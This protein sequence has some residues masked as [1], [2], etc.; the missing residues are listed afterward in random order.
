M[1]ENRREVVVHIGGNGK[2]GGGVPDDGELHMTLPEHGCTIHRY[3][4]TGIPVLGLGNG[5]MV[6]SGDAVVV[7]GRNQ[8]DR[9][10]VSGSGGKDWGR[11]LTEGK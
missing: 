4:I 2:G 5:T 7:T 1:T 8:S 6:A 10:K 11:R 9:F 3:A